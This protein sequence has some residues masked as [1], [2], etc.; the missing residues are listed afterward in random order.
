MVNKSRAVPHSSSLMI[1]QLLVVAV[2][3][4]LFFSSFFFS[5][6]MTCPIPQ[7][8]LWFC[9]CILCSLF[10]PPLPSSQLLLGGTGI[11]TDLKYVI[12]SAY[13]P[14]EDKGSLLLKK[15]RVGDLVL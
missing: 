1:V 7:R 14:R 11:A 12:S 3:C 2:C 10:F 8:A 6:L 4:L 5:F 15:T 13:N 9:S